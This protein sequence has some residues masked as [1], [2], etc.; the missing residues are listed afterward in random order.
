MRRRRLWS[1]R[2]RWDRRRLALH[3]LGVTPGL[4]LFVCLAPS[5]GRKFGLTLSPLALLLSPA[6]GFSSL[7]FILGFAR[8]LD[9]ASAFR[10][11]LL[12]LGY[13]FF[14]KALRYLCFALA[15]FLNSPLGLGF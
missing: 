2:T 4:C 3:P 13:G 6:L 7:S 10:F 11:V 15:L 9:L 12:A 5:F 14:F 8:R 1:L